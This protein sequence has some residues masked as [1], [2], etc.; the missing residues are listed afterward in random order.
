MR[1]D[2]YEKSPGNIMLRTRQ[3]CLLSLL[4]FK[5]VPEILARAIRQEKEKK[6]IHIGKEEVELCL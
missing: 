3:G 6:I 2:I 1:K 5:T 4:C